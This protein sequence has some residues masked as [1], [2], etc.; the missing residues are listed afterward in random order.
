VAPVVITARDVCERA[1]LDLNVLA[2]GE[3]LGADDAVFVLGELNTYLDELNAERA[4]VWAQVYS[5]W[6]LTPGLQPH[7]IGPTGTFVVAQRPETIE[8]V[9]ITV[10]QQRVPITIRDRAWF[11]ALTAPA[12]TAP[13][14]TDVWYNPV[15]PN[16]HLYFVPRPSAPGLIDLSTRQVLTD[17]ILTDTFSLPP[18]YRSM[19]QKTLAERVAAAYEKSVPPQLARDAAA[20][21]ARV[22]AANTEI[23]R[24]RTAD[25]GMPGTW[26]RG[27]AG[28]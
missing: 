24:L 8:G 3:V 1:L 7:L 9:A 12:Q 28:F 27:R 22:W 6:T 2:A 10:G 11:Q 20:A 4:A 16:G 13:Q 15:W 18:G 21:R 17:L 26:R 25:A 19:L 23:P 14:P 5:G